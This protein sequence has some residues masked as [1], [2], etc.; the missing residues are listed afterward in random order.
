MGVGHFFAELRH[1]GAWIDPVE[2]AAIECRARVFGEALGQRG[3]VLTVLDTVIEPL[4][5]LL[6]RRF[7]ANL[8]R[9]DQDVTD[10]HFVT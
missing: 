6:G 3:E 8:A 10:M 2:I 5:Q 9:L 7:A 4:G 1:Q